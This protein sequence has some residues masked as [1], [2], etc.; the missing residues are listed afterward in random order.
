MNINIIKALTAVDDMSIGGM[1]FWPERNKVVTK[2]RRV[3]GEKIVDPTLTLGKNGGF[4]WIG[5]SSSLSNTLLQFFSHASSRM[6][7]PEFREAIKQS[8]TGRLADYP[9]GIARRK[10]Y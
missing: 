10:D 6:T 2:F 5:S 1:Q 3:P 9:S 7:S 4:Q 8:N